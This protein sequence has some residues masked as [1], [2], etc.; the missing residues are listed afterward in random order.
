MTGLLRVDARGRGL[1]PQG[2]ILTDGLRRLAAQPRA[3]SGGARMAQLARL[4]IGTLRVGGGRER[5]RLRLGGR[6]LG[7]NAFLLLFV[8]RLRRVGRGRR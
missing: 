3:V 8:L 7:A 1:L 2:F 4:Q 6:Q 5:I